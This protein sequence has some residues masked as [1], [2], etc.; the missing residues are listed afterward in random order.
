MQPYLVVENILSNPDF[1]VEWSRALEYDYTSDCGE[2]ELTKRNSRT[3]VGWHGYRSDELTFIDPVIAGNVSRQVHKKVLN[4]R[5]SGYYVQRNYFHY[6]TQEIQY[7]DTWW[8]RDSSALAGVIYLSPD[9]EPES[10]TLIKIRDQIITV[11]NV[12]N[13]LVLYDANLIHRPQR[14]FGNSINTARLTMTIFVDQRT[15]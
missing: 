6:S 14:C 9:P 15:I 10:G 12:F 1:Y 8:H 5:I 13:R 2:L 3:D 4:N 7:D 11:D